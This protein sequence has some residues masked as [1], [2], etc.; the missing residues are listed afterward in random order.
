MHPVKNS[1]QAR[2]EVRCYNTVAALPS[3]CQN[4]FLMGEQDSFD[5]SPEWFR[6]LSDTAIPASQ[7]PRFYLLEQAGSARI[8]L[9]LLLPAPGSKVRD[10]TGLTNFYSTIFRPVIE[11]KVGASDLAT[12]LRQVIQDAKTGVLRFDAMDPE[13]PSFMLLHQALRQIGLLPFKFFG[14]GNWYLEAQNLSWEDYLKQLPG[15]HRNTLKRL[16]KKF[17]EAGGS[18]KIISGHEPGLDAALHA[19]QEVYASSWKVPE[20]YPNFIPGFIRMCAHQGWLRLGL[21]FI[22]EQ[23]VAAQFWLVLHGRAC[24]YKV[25]YNEKFSEFSPGSLLTGHLMR[26]VI[27]V[28]Q[29][30]EVDYLIGDDAY[31]KIW[32]SH[33]RERW[34]IVAYNP[35]TLGGLW[36]A[37][38][39]AMARTA[40]SLLNRIRTRPANS[41]HGNG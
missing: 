39:E 14:F 5:L 30:R 9:P 17:T 20:P 25:S 23:P 36:G 4:L 18:F 16:G 32:M 35:R 31:K 10:V 19:Y 1:S 29:V 40:K 24:I 28:D 22:G 6:L 11:R 21:A 26:H 37:L 12:L 8:L 34:G 2:C 27:E 3:T 13:H 33:R 38:R 15:K 41:R 7:M